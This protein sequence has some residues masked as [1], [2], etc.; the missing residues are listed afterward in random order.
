MENK[1]HVPV[2]A[3]GRGSNLFLICAEGRGV[4]RGLVRRVASVVCPL[5][6]WWSM[7]GACAVPCF[8]SLPPVLKS[9]SRKKV[10]VGVFGFFV[11]FGSRMCPKRAC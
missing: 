3:S 9:G 10:V 4:S 8:C 1:Q 11:S 5:L 7:Q 2:L 6:R